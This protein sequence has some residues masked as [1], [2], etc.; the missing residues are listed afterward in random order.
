MFFY[1]QGLSEEYIK[2]IVIAAVLVVLA[3]IFFWIAFRYHCLKSKII[4]GYT[5]SCKKDGMPG[6]TSQRRADRL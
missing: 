3:I 5:V 1:M 4:R 6:G 2:S